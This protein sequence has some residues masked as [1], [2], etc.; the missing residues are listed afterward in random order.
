MYDKHRD[1]SKIEGK[2]A[3]PLTAWFLGPKAENS[4]IW[5]ELFNYIFDDYIY[6]RRNYFPTDPIVVDRIKRRNHEFWYDKL[7]SQI[8][9]VL[10]RL[11]ADYPFYSP[12]YLAH[13]LSEQSLPAV[14]G[15]FA[16]MLYNPN[17]VTNEAAPVT[18]PLELEAGKMVAEMLGFNPELSWTHI[19]SGGTIANLE[20]F[21]VSRTIQFA[22]LVI[23]EYCIENAIDFQIQ[24][25]NHRENESISI[26]AVDQKKLLNIKPNEAIFMYRKLA[27]HLINDLQR[28]PMAVLDSINSFTHENQ[29]NV[30]ERG[31]C[32]LVK[33]LNMSPRIF[34]SEAAHYSIK[35]VADVLGYGEKNV[36]K[37]PVGSNFRMNVKELEK[38]LWNLSE[39][40][41]IAG[42]VGILGTTEEGAIDPIHEIK[43]LRDKLQIERNLSFWF[44]IDAAWGG[45]IK[46]L[47]NNSDLKKQ[48]PKGD[49]EGTCQLYIEKLAVR[50]KFDI[51]L[52][53][54]VLAKSLKIE[55]DDKSV[56]KALLAVE[57]ADSITIDP[58]KLG[59]IPYPAGMV[60]F[61]NGIVTEHIKQ[62]AQYISDEKG[63]LKSIDKLIDIKAVGPYI[64]EGSK[65]GAAAAA[66]WLAHKVIPLETHGH[67][68]IIRTTLLNTKKLSRCIDFHRHA[69]NPID[70]H[71]FGKENPCETPFT[72]KYLY[73]PD[74]N[75]VCFIAKPMKFK[76]KELDDVDYSLKNLNILNEALYKQLSI[77]DASTPYSQEFFVSRTTFKKNQYSY[78]S[79]QLILESINISEEEY[80]QYGLFVL[81]STVMNPWHWDAQLAGID[82]LFE[83][84]IMMHKITR[85]ILENQ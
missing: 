41:Y 78:S 40:E 27:G 71:L 22:P 39:D 26:T 65:P 84:V 60:S 46:S 13:M 1:P 44:H 33:E 47:F 35:K 54:K 16:G 14:V 20:A 61:K 67:G 82:Y 49:I 75:V 42:V 15:Y 69:F 21:W 45:Y 79:I 74:S 6:W 62:E 37:I 31:M 43:S 50:E 23:R 5:K 12:R 8:D 9:T 57:S 30:A 83:F 72:F 48:E 70:E 51:H 28:D 58:H 53:E 7:T 17:N 32:E 59:Y 64:L 36:V 85:K 18:V 77:H 38:A 76:N 4:S 81:R 55:W 52:N 63:G 2:T 11:K 3:N 29:Y 56:Y 10:N 24:L 34:V 68:K 19:T 25:P 73:P 80:N 66:T